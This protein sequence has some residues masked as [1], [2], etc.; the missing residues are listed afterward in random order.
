[1]LSQSDHFPTASLKNLSAMSGLLGR[2]RAFFDAHQFIEVI[3]PQLSQDTTINR[4][5][6]PIPVSVEVFPNRYQ[7]YYLQTSPE[8]CMKRILASGARA[9][10]QI[11][12]AFRSGDVGE[13]HNVEFTL[14]EWYRVGDEYEQGRDFLAELARDILNRGN[15]QIQA[16]GDCFFGFTGLN[17]HLA[18]CE[19]MRNF[20]DCNRIP[21]PETFGISVLNKDLPDHFQRESWVDLLF[22]EI[23]QPCLG[24]E[25]PVILYDYPIWQSQLARTRMHN[26]GKDS[27]EV[28]ERFELYVDG[29]EL[30]NGYHELTDPEELMRRNRESNRS[31]VADGNA[32]LPEKSR[33]IRA[34]ETG[35]PPCC[36]TALGIERLLMVLLEAQTIDEV[37]P[38]PF[39]RA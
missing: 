7:Q 19:E 8:F 17:P 6:Q 23:V 14:L 35:F 9:I 16:F 27:Y 5:L 2:I 33:L 26:S 36:G 21:Y 18:T 22:S 15:P 29:L 20:A 38:F 25:K 28:S 37:L 30:A 32:P 24:T 10:Y 4:F 31:R 12:H 11:A 34:M 1:M 39:D 13:H 3:T